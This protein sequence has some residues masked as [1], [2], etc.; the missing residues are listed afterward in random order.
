MPVLDVVPVP[1]AEAVHRPQSDEKPAHRRF[2]DAEE[3]SFLEL[4]DKVRGTLA[5]EKRAGERGDG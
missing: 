5:E 2:A 3:P 1:E 4:L